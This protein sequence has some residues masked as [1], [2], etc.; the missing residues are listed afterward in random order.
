MLTGELV[1]RV[2]PAFVAAVDPSTPFIAA[3]RERFPDVDV[4]EAGADDLPYPD[5]AF[6]VALAQLVVHFLPNPVAGLREMRRVVR[7]GG[8]VTACVWDH[9]GS[10]GPLAP[11]WDAARS[12]DPDVDDESGR[13]GTREGHLAQLLDAA[14]LADVEAA[15]I[16]V[17]LQVSDFEAWWAPFTFGVAGLRLRGL[18]GAVHLRRRAGRRVRRKPGRCAA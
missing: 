9:A 7:P 13:A 15:P 17:T 8:C 11:F 14:G 1:R 3:M 4:Q 2:G 6:D 16:T 18:V 5:D 12:M 10:R